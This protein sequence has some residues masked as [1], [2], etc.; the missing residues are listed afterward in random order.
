MLSAYKP[1]ADD[2]RKDAWISVEDRLPTAGQKVWV[3]RNGEV[4]AVM[5]TI[6]DGV[7][8]VQLNQYGWEYANRFMS[9]T[10]WQPEYNPAPPLDKARE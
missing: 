7:N 5:E 6:F 9:P 3:G 8:F 2:V 4:P 1:Q 10:H